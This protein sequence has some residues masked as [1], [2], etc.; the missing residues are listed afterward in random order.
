MG[1]IG[2][3]E[4]SV[5][6]CQQNLRNIPE[7]RGPQLQRDRSLKSLNFTVNFLNKVEEDF[8]SGL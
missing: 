8:R 3:P 5:T 7:E 4:T 6:N 1:R 2:Y